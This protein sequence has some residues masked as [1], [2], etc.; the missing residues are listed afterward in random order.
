V[1]DCG[2][3]CFVGLA[4]A[5]VG[6]VCLYPSMDVHCFVETPS[7][8]GLQSKGL[9]IICHECL[10]TLISPGR[11][12]ICGTKG[13]FNLT[14]RQVRAAIHKLS[15]FLGLDLLVVL[16]GASSLLMLSRQQTAE[17]GI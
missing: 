1:V 10:L 4:S 7:V 13:Y 3:V 5:L 16:N 9:F 14:P 8:K 6:L 11:N 2:R 12:A 15:M 17:M